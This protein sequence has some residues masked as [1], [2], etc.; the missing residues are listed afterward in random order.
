MALEGYEHQDVPFERLVEG[1]SPERSLNTTPIFQVV[2]ALQNAPWMP[3]QMK[4]LEVGPVMG[5][6]LRVKY[7]LE[8]HAW[9]WEGDI[10]CPGSITGTCSMVG[11]WSRW[12]AT[13]CE[14]WRR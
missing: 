12:G 13:I 14:W 2:F 8:V 7:D 3:E 1:F 4:G 9:E 10:G 5:D 11:G 6:E